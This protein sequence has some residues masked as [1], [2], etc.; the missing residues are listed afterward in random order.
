M[1]GNLTAALPVTVLPAALAA[2]FDQALEYYC[3][4]NIYRDGTSQRSTDVGSPR[5]TWRMTRRLTPVVLGALAA[6]YAA[7]LGPIEPFYFYNPFEPGDGLA[8]GSN[9]DAT[10]INPQGRYTVRFEGS[11]KPGYDKGRSNVSLELVE[12]L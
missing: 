6:F 12:I 11:W 4:E 7:R 2:S 10:G 3:K 1:P 5:R 8:I 9:Y